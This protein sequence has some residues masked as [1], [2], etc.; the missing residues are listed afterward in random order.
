MRLDPY[1]QAGAACRSATFS[2]GWPV[3]E[4]RRAIGKI[5]RK[6]GE[7]GVSL[8]A[9]PRKGLRLESWFEPACTIDT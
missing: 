2:S 6:N 1:P 3:V 7:V 9:T 4:C 5:C 8:P